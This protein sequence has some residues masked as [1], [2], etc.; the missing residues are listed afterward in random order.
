MEQCPAC[1]AAVGTRLTLCARC[2]AEGWQDGPHHLTADELTIFLDRRRGERP[3]MP[4]GWYL[5]EDGFDR[6]AACL[7]FAVRRLYRATS[8]TDVLTSARQRT[9]DELRLGAWQQV[10]HLSAYAAFDRAFPDL[11]ILPW[12]MPEQPPRGYWEVNGD[13]A[14]AAAMRWW[15]ERERVTA[16]EVWDRWRRAGNDLSSRLRAA[17]LGYIVHERSIEYALRLVDP[18]LPV[19]GNKR[20]SWRDAATVVCPWCGARVQELGTHRTKKHPDRSR[21]ELLA[22]LG[23]A[24]IST[25]AVRARRS[26]ASRGPRHSGP[27]AARQ[28]A[29]AVWVK[30][31]LSVAAGFWPHARPYMQL[32]VHEETQSIRILPA[33]VAGAG[34]RA[35]RRRSHRVVLRME[36]TLIARL[37]HMPMQLARERIVFTAGS[38][39]ELMPFRIWSKGQRSISDMAILPSRQAIMIKEDLWP[40]DATLAAVAIDERGAIGVLPIT[41]TG[42]IAVAGRVGMTRRS[43]VRLDACYTVQ[44]NGRR[45]VLSAHAF[46]R[47]TQVPIGRWRLTGIEDDFLRFVADGELDADE[48]DEAAHDV[49]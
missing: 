30:D 42:R 26:R 12:E 19:H 8:R 29:D 25:E 18:S 23:D 10:N 39:E 22:A 2:R 5:G 15:L 35:I 47:E 16:R 1:G 27:A 17:G 20:A 44:R 34:R 36:P 45:A 24:P 37:Q 33:T 31:G 49:V 40:I 11:E 38:E 32:S 14:I 21:A 7:R 46:L 48:A 6:G 43:P 28:I 3:K 9:I 41:A 13:A 4:Q